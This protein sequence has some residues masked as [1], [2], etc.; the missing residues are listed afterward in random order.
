M[1]RRVLT[2]CLLAFLCCP[3]LAAAQSEAVARGGSAFYSGLA[4]MLG[5]M[6]APRHLYLSF[7]AQCM[8]EKAATLAVAPEAREAVILLLRQQTLADMQTEKGKKALQDKLVTALN[9][10]IGSPRVVRVIF[11]RFAIM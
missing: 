5:T 2:L 1:N 11:T 7:T 3:A 8:D 4:V 6:D 9:K 10:A